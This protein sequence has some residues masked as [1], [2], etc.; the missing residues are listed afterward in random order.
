MTRRTAAAWMQA[1]SSCFAPRQCLRPH[2]SGSASS[3]SPR[4]VSRAQDPTRTSAQS[5]GKGTSWIRSWGRLLRRSTPCAHSGGEDDEDDD[6]SRGRDPV[7]CDAVDRTN[8]NEWR[9]RLDVVTCFV[10]AGADITCPNTAEGISSCMH[11]TI[12][13]GCTRESVTEGSASRPKSEY[14]ISCRSPISPLRSARNV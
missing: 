5:S 4:H 3:A 6:T 2:R 8:K 12:C 14:T 9:A 10:A 7:D 13:S 11:A 1:R